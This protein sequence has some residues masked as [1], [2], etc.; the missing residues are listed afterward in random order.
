MIEVNIVELKNN[1]SSLNSLIEEFNNVEL[2]LFNRLKESCISWQDNNS[3]KFDSDIQLDKREMTMFINSLIAKKNVFDIAYNKYSEI[4]KKIKCNLNSKN[5]ILNSI[6]TN[7]SKCQN[8]IEE[9]NRIDRSFYYNEQHSI[10]NQ[11]NLIIMAKTSL[12]EIRWSVSKLYNKVES[13]EKIIN[14]KIAGLEDIKINNFD[15]ISN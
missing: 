8:I 13:I 1:I 12:E 2:N 10:Q 5:T 6:D 3:I 11:K 7:I 9:F 4:G 14:S 15:Y